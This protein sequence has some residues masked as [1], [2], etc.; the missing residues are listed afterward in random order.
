MRLFFL[1]MA[2]RRVISRFVKFRIIAVSGILRYVVDRIRSYFTL[3]I[4]ELKVK[5][6]VCLLPTCIVCVLS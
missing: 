1:M 2:M 4:A 3:I 6:S 5:R